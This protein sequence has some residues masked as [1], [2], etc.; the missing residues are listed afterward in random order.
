MHAVFLGYPPDSPVEAIGTEAMATLSLERSPQYV[1]AAVAKVL[2]LQLI[3][4]DLLGEAWFVAL[5]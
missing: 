1:V 5:H 4:Q 2:I 3:G